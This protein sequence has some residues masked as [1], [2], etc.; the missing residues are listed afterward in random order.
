MTSDFF[1]TRVRIIRPNGEKGEDAPSRFIGFT[2]GKLSLFTSGRASTGLTD[3]D[4]ARVSIRTAR[5]AVDASAGNAC[6]KPPEGNKLVRYM[7]K[8]C[9]FSAENR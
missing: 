5:R 3:E 6:R 2:D 9:G 7:T 1:P 8:R 4:I